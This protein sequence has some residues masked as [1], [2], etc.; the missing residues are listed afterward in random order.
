MFL[1][2]VFSFC[3]EEIHFRTGFGLSHLIN[4]DIEDATFRPGFNIGAGLSWMMNESTTARFEYIYHQKGAI[5]GEEPK[6][7][8]NLDYFQ[9]NLIGLSHIGKNIHIGGGGYVNMKMI[10]NQVIET[11]GEER[12]LSKE[13][14]TIIKN[15]GIG[16]LARIEYQTKPANFFLEYNYTFTSIFEESAG[17]NGVFS[18][19]AIWRIYKH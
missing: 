11:S 16:A 6:L 3:Q 5:A 12:T 4:V 15:N 14:K 9:I 2:P 13:E 19:G 17:R 7:L 10:N 8:L 1:I 18:A